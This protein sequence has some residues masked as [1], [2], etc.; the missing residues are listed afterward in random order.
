MARVVHWP[1]CLRSELSTGRV[2]QGPSCPRAEVSTVR[3]V[4]H[5]KYTHMH[6]R[7]F[8]PYQFMLLVVL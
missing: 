6:N 2:V 5:S 8:L 7:I 1:R 3:V 4:P